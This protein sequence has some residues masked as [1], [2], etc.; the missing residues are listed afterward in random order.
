MPTRRPPRDLSKADA[1]LSNVGDD[2]E[3]QTSPATAPASPSESSKKQTS[4]KSKAKPLA[5]SKDP[6]FHKTMLYM[7]T[8]LFVALKQD[9]AG[10]PDEDMSD[11]VIKLL[12]KKYPKAEA[13]YNSSN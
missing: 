10:K 12:R 4:K 3:V 6:D 5:K 7:P 8:A 2:P 13:E 9:A 11:I 1:L